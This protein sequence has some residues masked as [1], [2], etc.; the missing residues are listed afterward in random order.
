MIM[1]KNIKRL[2]GLITVFALCLSFAGCNK[3]TT[4]TVETVPMLVTDGTTLTYNEFLATNFGEQV[5]VAGYVQ[6]KMSY[7]AEETGDGNTSMFIKDQTSDN[8]YFLYNVR[9]TQAVYDSITEGTPI[10]VTGTKQVFSNEVEIA[11]GTIEV[12][13]A[14]PVI[15]QPLD[16]TTIFASSASDYINRKIQLSG[17]VVE[18]WEDGAIFRYGYNGTGSAGDA[19]FF[20]ASQGGVTYTFAVNPYLVGGAES[21]VYT[22]VQGLQQGQSITIQGYMYFYETPMVQVTSIA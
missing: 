5:V 7:I 11:N 3:P 10:K 6:A 19:I 16:I 4:P 15:A 12:L 1:T 2:L 8:A 17:F 18:T 14:S 9:L 20:R 22:A 13:S 21:T